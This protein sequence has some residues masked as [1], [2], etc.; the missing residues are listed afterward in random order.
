MN[1]DDKQ[2]Y[3]SCKDLCS[4]FEAALTRAQ[5]KEIARTHFKSR[6]DY[7][8]WDAYTEDDH[9]TILLTAQEHGKRLWI[10]EHGGVLM[11]RQL[12]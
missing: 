6:V 10:Q 9:L 2:E 4:R 11:C 3:P 7:D 1:K 5:F 12:Y 8:R